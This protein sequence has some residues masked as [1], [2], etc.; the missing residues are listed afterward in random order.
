MWYKTKYMKMS[1]LEARRSVRNLAFGIYNFEIVKCFSYLGTV[2]K[3]ENRVTEEINKRIMAG[4]T[5]YFA[6]V[7][8][9]RSTV[10]SWQSDVKIFNTLIS[11]V[12][13]YGAETWPMSAADENALRVFERKV[14]RRVYGPVR[15]CE[16]WRTR[17]N[18]ELE[19]I[20][21]R[22]DIVI[23]VKSRR[24]TWLGKGCRGSCYMGEWKDGG[25]MEDRGRDGC[26]TLKRT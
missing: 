24:L 6:N 8:L 14:L 22:E 21:R 7:K 17:S 11:P 19:E 23:F 12:V 1:E 20:L 25:D 18:R 10:L 16:N 3:N 4:N 2:L 5:A 13:T 15:E 26:R 9:L